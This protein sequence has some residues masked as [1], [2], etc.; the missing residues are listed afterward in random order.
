M[1]YLGGIYHLY[2]VC[3]TFCPPTTREY[4]KTGPPWSCSQQGPLIVSSY[5]AVFSEKEITF[6]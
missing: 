1:K 6:R 5:R 4:K 2:G 3:Y